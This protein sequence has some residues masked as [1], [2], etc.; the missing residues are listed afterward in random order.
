MLFDFQKLSLLSLEEL[1]KV[2]REG[3]VWAPICVDSGDHKGLVRATELRVSAHPDVL[4]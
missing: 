2:E 3:L 4:A 1:E